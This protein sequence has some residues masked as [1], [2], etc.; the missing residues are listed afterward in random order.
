MFFYFY[1]LALYY[2]SFLGFFLF[3]RNNF[4]SLF[5]PFNIIMS[6]Q[7]FLY[8]KGYNSLLASADFNE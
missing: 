2:N 7:F 4:S 3:E 6:F 5:F 8:I 1:F